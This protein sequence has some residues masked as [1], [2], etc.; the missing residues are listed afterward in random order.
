[1]CNAR[2]W[3]S[4][5]G[6]EKTV[7]ELVDYDRDTDVLVVRVRPTR[8]ARGRCGLCRA[9]CPGYDLGQG[10]RRWRALDLGTVRAVLEADA[11]RVSCRVHGVVVADV[12]WA[13]HGA[14]H[15]H[16]FDDTVAWLAV[17]CSKTAVRTLMRIA[18]RTV[19][20][21]VTRVAA[22]ALA[23]TDRFAGL[24]RIGIDEIA[25]KR[26]H[27]YLTIVVDHD[28]R[29]LIWAAPGR[30]K[31]TLRSFF[32]ALGADR[33]ARIT[34]VSADS[35]AWIAEEVAARCPKAVQCADA[36]HVVKWATEALD[37]TRIQAWN[38]ARALART[39]PGR[40]QGRQRADAPPRPGHDRAK[41]LRDSR[42]A[43]WKNPDNL[44][45]KQSAKLAWI[46]KTDPRLHRAYLLKEG[47]RLVFVLKGEHGKQA[48]E[49]WIR[50]ARRC[51]IPAFVDLQRRIV[52]HRATIHATLDHGLSNGL[53]ES[54]NTKIRL[55]TRL[56]FG[57]K[58]PY[59]LIALAMLALGGLCPPLPGRTNST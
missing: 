31:A 2:V 34:H 30:D 36:F 42:Y 45:D 8:S 25:Y 43:L 5:L 40:A 23:G 11:P 59:A 26:G 32:D 58:D 48:L 35:A 39:E 20:A 37:R 3:R 13:R 12:P 14:G 15:T 51:R 28:T 41:K 33:C 53:I 21:I 19:G 44:T 6:V 47:L 56:A 55:L 16:A 27:R 17:Q 1:V 50:W 24:S 38:E 4:L 18:W 22:D 49:G 7:I 10:R 54:T 9:R 57:F 52:K 29:Q 46:A